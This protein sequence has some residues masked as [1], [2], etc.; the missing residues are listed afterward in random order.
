MIVHRIVVAL[1]VVSSFK[2]FGMRDVADVHSLLR[3]LGNFWNIVWRRKA[4]ALSSML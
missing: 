2:S 3:G 4:P 1:Q